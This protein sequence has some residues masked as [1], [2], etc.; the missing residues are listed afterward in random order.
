MTAAPARSG[1]DVAGCGVG[2]CG[3]GTQLI[4]RCL[5]RSQC[6]GEA[7]RV[8][9]VAGKREAVGAAMDGGDPSAGGGT[10]GGG[11]TSLEAGQ[12]E[13]G[14][15]AAGG[16]TTGGGR[17][18]RGRRCCRSGRLSKR[19]FWRRSRDGAGGGGEGRGEWRYGGAGEGGAA[20][21]QRLTHSLTFKRCG[22]T[23]RA[24]ISA[25]HAPLKRCGTPPST[26]D[27]PIRS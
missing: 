19:R 10:T 22:R 18:R 1:R 13:A 3:P 8:P 6:G 5:T 17:Q 25:L 7:R 2:S 23:R 12:P 14:G 11:A 26:Q 4:R 24:T 20:W 16:E 21:V 9:A 15:N 27:A